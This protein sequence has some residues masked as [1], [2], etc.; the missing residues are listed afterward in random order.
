MAKSTEKCW[1]REQR[2]MHMNQFE[3]AYI[4]FSGTPEIAS[5]CNDINEKYQKSHQASH[6]IE[7]LN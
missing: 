3:D 5:D 6:I 7:S 4:V 2:N 1:A